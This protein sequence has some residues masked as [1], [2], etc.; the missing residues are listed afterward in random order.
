MK[1]TTPERPH[2]TFSN[3]QGWEWRVLKTYQKPEK[4]ACNLYA[5]W[6]CAVSSPM[7]YGGYDMGDTYIK[8]ILDV[9][10]YC[11]QA[12]DEFKSLYPGLTV[13]TP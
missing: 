11:I 10:V 4:E 7:T 8:D 3:G 2:A 13:N 6:M 9:G 12:S 5:R 1:T